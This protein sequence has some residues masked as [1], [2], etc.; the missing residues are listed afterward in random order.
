M[1]L[2]KFFLPPSVFFIFLMLV[3]CKFQPNEVVPIATQKSV[4]AIYTECFVG[5]QP[6]VVV[7]RTRNIGEKIQWDFNYKDIV[8]KTRDTTIYNIYQYLFDTVKDVTVQLYEAD[9]LI[10]T[11]KQYNPYTKI[12]YIADGVNYKQDVEYTLKVFAPG[13]DT[14]VGKQKPPGDVKL[15][16]VDFSFNNTVSRERS[17]LLSELA[18]EFDDV[19]NQE[20]YYAAEVYY[21][22]GPADKKTSSRI[23]PIKLDAN[24]TNG[25]FLSD[26]TFDGKKYVWRLGLELGDKLPPQKDSVELKI[27]FRT[28]A[29]DYDLY[30][31]SAEINALAG[32]SLFAEPTSTYTNL[33]GGIG[34]FTIFGEAS[35]YTIKLYK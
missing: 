24:A 11:F 7:T 3:A 21:R 6:L 15:N 5:E 9:R 23:S 26:R 17:T 32:Q 16:K 35:V 20:N 13:F 22:M 29:K 30:Q 28:A 27:Y 19:P 25:V 4:L 14:V 18:L 33:T 31:K 34:V 10:R 12:S 1:K 8:E 2:I